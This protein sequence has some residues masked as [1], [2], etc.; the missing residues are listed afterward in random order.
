MS[1]VE[2]LHA[3]PTL[4]GVINNQELCLT[5]KGIASLAVFTFLKSI[6]GDYMHPTRPLSGSNRASAV[7]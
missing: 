2:N 7:P 3:K 5:A 6:V 4:S 1:E